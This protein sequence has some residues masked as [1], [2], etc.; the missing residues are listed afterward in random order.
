MKTK[1][2][3]PSGTEELKQSVVLDAAG[4]KVLND[5]TAFFQLSERDRAQILR[6]ARTIADLDG[7]EAVRARHVVEA[8]NLYLP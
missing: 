2:T 1:N 4:A 6:M 7:S 5:A 3:P 8:A